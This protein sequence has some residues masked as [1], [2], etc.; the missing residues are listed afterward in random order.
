MNMGKVM[1]R[2]KQI[3]AIMALASF[4]LIASVIWDHLDRNRIPEPDEL[5]L[6]FQDSALTDARGALHPV[7]KWDPAAGERIIYVGQISLGPAFVDRPDL[8]KFQRNLENLTIALSDLTGLSIAPSTTSTGDIEI[9]LTPDHAGPE[10]S[11]NAL[12][13]SNRIHKGEISVR[14]GDLQARRHV[15]CGS[16]RVDCIE[17][18]EFEAEVS[19]R[20]YKGLARVFGLTGIPRSG[21]S[22]LRQDMTFT[23]SDA[24]ALHILYQGELYPGASPAEAMGIARGVAEKATE[25]GTLGRFLTT[26]ESAE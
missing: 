24:V 12:V 14:V 26:L 8:L 13:R 23:A 22:I 1:T 15:N 10:V 9:L 5:V 21:R 18:H 2:Q 19:R 20:I 3:L 17:Q 6:F 25:S 16:D 7:R 4:G 11:N